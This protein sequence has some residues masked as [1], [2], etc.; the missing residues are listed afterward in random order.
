MR[1]HTSLN[2]QACLC[3]ALS[4]GSERVSYLHLNLNHNVSPW[5]RLLATRSVPGVRMRR[6]GTRG[7][8]HPRQQYNRK[9][10]PS[11][12]R[13]RGALD[14]AL[15]SLFLSLYVATVDRLV[16]GWP[17]DIHASTRHSFLLPSFLP[18]CLPQRAGTRV[19]VAPVAARSLVHPYA[20]PATASDG[21]SSHG[22]ARPRQRY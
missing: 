2:I 20:H 9:R 7:G 12:H 16:P 13:A 22:P 5:S 4:R 15:P 19:D 21:P 11:E 8:A 6:G 18:A 3:S 10:F 14:T 17:Y 1:A